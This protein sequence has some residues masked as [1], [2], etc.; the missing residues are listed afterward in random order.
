[1]RCHGFVA[2][3]LAVCL[4]SGGRS[5][6]NRMLLLG[7][8]APPA[9]TVIGAGT[10][11]VTQLMVPRYPD[12]THPAGQLIGWGPASVIRGNA[13]TQHQPIPAIVFT[14][15]AD[16]TV[17]TYENGSL[18]VPAVLQPI[19]RDVTIAG[20]D[21]EGDGYSS[22]GLLPATYTTSASSL[23]YLW[24]G[25]RVTGS[26]RK[27]GWRPLL[28]HPWRRLRIRGAGGTLAGAGL[29][30]DRIKH[31]VHNCSVARSYGG[32]SIEAVD[33]VVGN[34]EDG[35]IRDYGLKLSGGACQIDGDST[36]MVLTATGRY[37][38]PG[39]LDDEQRHGKYGA[40][41]FSPRIPA[42]ACS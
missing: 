30:F 28:L 7:G 6:D 11:D 13:K 12:G 31:S 40:A 29:Q 20:W 15:D 8:E 3:G 34:L 1:M 23:P 24:D 37:A 42:M 25:S 5:D 2:M 17:S 22:A 35:W 32:F 18:S 14:Q 10:T 9:T 33:T 19:I 41:P 21:S 39:C 36:C 27:D 26:R 16:S 4:A 38:E